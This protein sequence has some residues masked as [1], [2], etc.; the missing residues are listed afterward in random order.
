LLKLRGFFGKL[1]LQHKLNIFLDRCAIYSGKM[2]ARF[3][4]PAVGANVCVTTNEVVHFSMRSFGYAPLFCILLK[5][6]N[7]RNK[8]ETT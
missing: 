4:A 2:Y 7:P 8:E 3:Y 6:Q 1:T 5:R